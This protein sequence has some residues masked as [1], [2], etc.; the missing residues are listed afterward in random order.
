MLPFIGA[1]IGAALGSAI[2]AKDIYEAN[3][4]PQFR[5][6]PSGKGIKARVSW[7]F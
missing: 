1:L 5:I 2:G 3:S 4:G 7:R 6:A